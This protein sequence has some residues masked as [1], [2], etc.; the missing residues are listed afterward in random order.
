[1]IHYHTDFIKIRY[2]VK[3]MAQQ[4]FWWQLGQDQLVHQLTY[5]VIIA[6]VQYFA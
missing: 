3:D 6:S 2:G 1:L 5:V 4:K